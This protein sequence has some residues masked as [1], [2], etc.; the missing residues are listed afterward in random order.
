MNNI[1]IVDDSATAR[2]MIGK[3][4]EMA[5]PG[6][7]KLLEA[8]H[9]NEAMAVLK[10]NLPDLVVSDLNMPEMDGKSLLRKIKAS[11]RLNDLPVII[12]TS[13]GNTQRELELKELGAEFVLNKPVTPPMIS[14]AIGFLKEN[15]TLV[16]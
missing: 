11:P 9:G 15:G 12:I 7:I 13:A 4:I 16:S 5:L 14:E 6:D 10:D 1:L 3:C 8:C 2:M